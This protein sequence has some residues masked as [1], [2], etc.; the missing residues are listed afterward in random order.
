MDAFHEFLGKV[1]NAIIN[2]LITLIALAAF[3]IFL[4][5][6]VE[7]IRDSADAEKRK[8]GQQ[9]IVWGLVGLVIMFGAR[10]IMAI[11]AHTFGLTVPGA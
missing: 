1:E 9:H 7:F 10:A 5:G 8:K 11:A 4:W 6:V 2:P 3:V